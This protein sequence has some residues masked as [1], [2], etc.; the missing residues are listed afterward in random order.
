MILI[1]KN[2]WLGICDPGSNESRVPRN[3]VKT[4]AGE[5]HGHRNKRDDDWRSG[6]FTSLYIGWRRSSRRDCH[7]RR[8]KVDGKVSF[9]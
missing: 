7:L 2:L 5:D 6:L 1:E 3:E 8:R 4:I 9:G